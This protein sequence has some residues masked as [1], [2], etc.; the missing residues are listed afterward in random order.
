[1]KLVTSSTTTRFEDPDDAGAWVEMRP[2]TAQD[3]ASL[4]T[5]LQ[6]AQYSLEMLKKTIVAW[7]LD[8]PVTAENIAAVD[9]P[10]FSWL[11]SIVAEG[12]G[13]RK[14]ADLNASSG[15]SPQ[16]SATPELSLESSTTSPS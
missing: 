11:D 9:V 8:V 2:L 13:I 16:A 3:F 7:S 12:A 6:P 10:T 5:S 1:M 4:D 14:D 15:S